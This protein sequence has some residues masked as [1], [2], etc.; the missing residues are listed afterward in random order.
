LTRRRGDAEKFKKSREIKR[1]MGGNLFHPLFLNFSAS[2][3]LR[4]KN[5]R[6]KNV[7]VKNAP[8]KNVRVKNVPVKNVRVRTC[9]STSS[10]LA[11]LC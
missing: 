5:V 7:R 11:A 6:V 8:V 2:L 3:R 10:T 1:K 4:V 9:A